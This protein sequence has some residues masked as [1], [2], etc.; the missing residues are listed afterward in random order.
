MVETRPKDLPTQPTLPEKDEGGD[1]ARA[2]APV[3]EGTSSPVETALCLAEEPVEVSTDLTG[4]LTGGG[5]LTGYDANPGDDGSDVESRDG[6]F[7]KNL[8]RWYNR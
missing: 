5:D 6:S 2:A 3:E 4:D 1:E 8:V 7:I